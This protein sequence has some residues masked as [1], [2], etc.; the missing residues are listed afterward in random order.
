MNINE[1]KLAISKGE[2]SLDELNQLTNYIQSVKVN[3]AKRSLK[4]G[5][6]VFVV[7]KTKRT[8]GV[9]RDIKIKKAIVSMR[10][11]QYNVPLSMIE[12][13]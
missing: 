4:V 1:I 7:Q 2:F 11:R 3:Q 12:P 13:A 5:D 9:I 8:Y 6:D 10:G